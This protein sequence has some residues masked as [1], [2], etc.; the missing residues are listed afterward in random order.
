MG[1]IS[2]VNAS[3]ITS[4]AGVAVAN[5]SYVGPI[6]TATIG[7]GGG[8]SKTPSDFPYSFIPSTDV[9]G[10]N[11]AIASDIGSIYN[12]SI[13][14]AQRDDDLNNLIKNP[15]I[16]LKNIGSKFYNLNIDGLQ[17][18]VISQWVKINNF[19]RK[20]NQGH[21]V[22]KKRTS[23][24]RYDFKDTNV[25]GL[26]SGFIEFGAI[27]PYYTDGVNFEGLY[28]GVFS[29]F[30]FGVCISNYKHPVSLYT[31]YSFQLETWYML[32]VE[33]TFEAGTINQ[34]DSVKGV[35]LWVDNKAQQTALFLGKPWRNRI[36]NYGK[37]NINK[38]NSG[39]LRRGNIFA[40]VPGFLDYNKNSIPSSEWHSI[41]FNSFVNITEM[42]YASFS[43]I[44]Y[45]DSNNPNFINN[46]IHQ[47]HSYSTSTSN[48]AVYNSRID[49][50]AL[51]IYGGDTTPAMIMRDFNPYK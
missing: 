3:T 2:G 36:T 41:Y 7:L 24:S 5:I 48:A 20:L 4:I 35:R 29:P 23:I 26:T 25:P 12:Y 15:T 38:G 14:G 1:Q 28:K 33:I 44:K 22:R 43:P 47:P 31:D 30:S 21:E 9:L 8:G 39:G 40:N 49:F 18:Y 19:P 16:E 45:F 11:I 17:K 42:N 46:S 34:A 10:A 13:T 37:N 32:S 50:G 51:N 27:A 6:S